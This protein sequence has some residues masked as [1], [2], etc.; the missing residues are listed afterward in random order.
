MV[1]RLYELMGTLCN[2]AYNGGWHRRVLPLFCQYQS[3]CRC[4][5][6]QF[7]SWSLDITAQGVDDQQRHPGCA[8]LLMDFRSRCGY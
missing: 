2:L 1:Q 8:S 5:K 3:W 6:S 7:S 4:A